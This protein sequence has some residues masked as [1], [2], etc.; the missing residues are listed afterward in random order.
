M[1]T[2]TVQD[3]AKALNFSIVTPDAELSRTIE[4]PFLNRPGMEMMGFDDYFHSTI[5]QRVQLIGTKEW[6]F[7]NALSDEEL[8]SQT[9]LLFNTKT[10]VIIFANNYEVPTTLLE[11]SKQTGVPI[12]QS[13]KST[14]E[15]F[16]TVFNYL[17]EALAETT[18]HHGVLVDVNGVGVMITGKS[19]IGKSET[20]LE[21]IRRGHQLIADDRV[22][23]YEKEIGLL[24]G[25]APEILRKFIEIRGIGIINVVEMFGAGA[26]RDS[27]RLE[28]VIELEDWS[29]DKEYNRIGLAEE[30]TR[31]FDT[32]VA[33]IT[34]PVKTGRSIASLIEV[35]AMNHRLQSMGYNAAEDFTNNLD[36]FIATRKG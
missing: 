28:L 2:V 13:G 9:G 22:D 35:A 16:A 29:P 25:R 19:S 12:I 32:E 36:R 30:T 15:A 6:Q 4:E 7:L 27:K 24:I 3:L 21:L 10:P 18:S 26:Y 17:Q 20:G 8:R 23:L 14:S 34:I 11:L 5:K 1:N 33:K 31:I